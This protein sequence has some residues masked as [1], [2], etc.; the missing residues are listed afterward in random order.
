MDLKDWKVWL[1]IVAGIFAFL[2]P[3]GIKTLQ[4]Q[5]QSTSQVQEYLNQE[6]DQ[7]IDVIIYDNNYEDAKNL[8]TIKYPGY[9]IEDYVYLEGKKAYL[10]RLKKVEK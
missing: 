9:I 3:F 4:Y 7:I 10:F 8:L 6:E 1:V 5:E 2:L